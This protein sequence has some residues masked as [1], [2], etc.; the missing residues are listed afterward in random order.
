LDNNCEAVVVFHFD[1]I[2][3]VFATETE[4]LRELAKDVASFSIFDLNSWLLN[5][6]LQLYRLEACLP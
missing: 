1:F 3:I 6:K 2:K 4:M 5:K